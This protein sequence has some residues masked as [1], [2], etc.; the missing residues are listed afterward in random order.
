M[1]KKRWGN[2]ITI[3]GGV[4]TQC[5]IAFGT[6]ADVDAEV[7]TRMKYVAPGGGYVVD[8]INTAWSPRARKN[9]LRYLERIHEMG[10]Y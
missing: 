10:V 3:W 2:K 1:I 8:F 9:V 5:T 7:A 6:Q 4:S